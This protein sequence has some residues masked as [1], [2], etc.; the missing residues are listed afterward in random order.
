M[1]GDFLD[2]ILLGFI[3]FEENDVVFTRILYCYTAPALHELYRKLCM[4]HKTAGT[5]RPLAQ[6]LSTNFRAS[7]PR[8]QTRC[9]PN[10][11]F[12]SRATCENV[13]VASSQEELH[14]VLLPSETNKVQWI[15]QLADSTY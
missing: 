4:K 3:L 2:V 15:R 5:G 7:Q 11:K 6:V 1:Y 14:K 13:D 8:S 12:N 9:R 10:V